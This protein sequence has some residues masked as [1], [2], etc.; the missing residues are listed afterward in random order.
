MSSTPV[1]GT[2][3]AKEIAEQPVAVRDTLAALLP[4]RDELAGLAGD[5][6][7]VLFVG[8]GTSDNAAIYH[9]RVDVRDSQPNVVTLVSNR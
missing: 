7:R 5:R 4:L 2:W 3:M 1:T 6:P 9:S 8:R